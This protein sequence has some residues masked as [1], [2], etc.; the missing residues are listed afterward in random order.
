MT[1]MPGEGAT[2]HWGTGRELVTV[3]VALVDQHLA[4]LHGP[5]VAIEGSVRQLQTNL[6]SRRGNAALRQRL[7][8]REQV[9]RRSW[10]STKNN[11][12]A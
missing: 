1:N 4:E 3:P 6:C 9:S 7:P 5:G 2:G 11:R 12:G 10:M 8:Q